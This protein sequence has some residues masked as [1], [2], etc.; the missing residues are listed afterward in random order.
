MND[1]SLQSKQ[2][3]SRVI[4]WLIFHNFF[5][6]D[7]RVNLACGVNVMCDITQ[8]CSLPQ[9]N[10]R[11][12]FIRISKFYTLNIN[13]RNTYF[14]VHPLLNS[15]TD[16][17]A[18]RFALRK[19]KKTVLRT[20]HENVPPSTNSCN[21]YFLQF[22]EEIFSSKWHRVCCC[23]HLALVSWPTEFS[24]PPCV[25]KCQLVNSQASR[26]ICITGIRGRSVSARSVL[27]SG[28]KSTVK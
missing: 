18:F 19:K 26:Y 23:W 25:M 21:K 9:T 11:P 5:C 6:L 13:A 7:V 22:R 3:C 10:I 27:P 8:K 24:Q 1:D 20:T 15:H 16:I 14:N 2:C 28:L 12:K 4:L 17:N